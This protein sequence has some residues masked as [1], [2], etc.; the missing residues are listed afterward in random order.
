MCVGTQTYLLW[1]TERHSACTTKKET[2]KQ[3]MRF[4]S[5]TQKLAAAVHTPLTKRKIT[6][7]DHP[8][9]LSGP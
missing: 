9:N 5:A 6:F 3:Y 8:A 1:L 2:D 4:K 7:D